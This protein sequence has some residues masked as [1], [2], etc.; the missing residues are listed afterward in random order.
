MMREKGDDR[1][2]QL[3]DIKSTSR[4]RSPMLPVTLIVAFVIIVGG[5]WLWHRGK[6]P[7]P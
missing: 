5:A 7:V 1:K 4:P 6:P 2:R 3:S